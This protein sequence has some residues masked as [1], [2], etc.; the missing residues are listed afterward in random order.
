MRRAPSRPLRLLLLLSWCTAAVACSQ[1]ERPASALL[2]TI[3]TLR[4][5]SVGAYRP[6]DPVPSATPRIDALAQQGVLFEHAAAP[7]PLTRPSHFSI[8][9]SLYPRE[10][11][12]LNNAIALPEAA[13]TLPELLQA[14]GYRTAAF[15][16]VVLLGKSSGAGQGFETLLHPTDP[17]ERPA[18][19]AVDEALAWLANVEKA[20]SFFLWVHVFDPHLPYAPPEAFRPESPTTPGA[21]TSLDWPEFVGI[22][23]ANDGD[24]PAATLER[25]RDLY[26]GE[27]RYADRE[28]GRL[29]D[30][31]TEH[32]RGSDTVVA[33]TAD[34]GEA[35]GHGTY[36]EHADSLFDGAIAIPL[37]V[38]GNA[39]FSGAERVAAQVSSLDIAPTLLRALGLDVPAGLSGSPLQERI[40][41]Q[42]RGE[43]EKRFVLIQHPFYQ[44]RVAQNRPRKRKAIRSVAGEPVD[45]ILLDTEK[46]GIVGTDWKLTRT[47]DAVEL[48]HR[49]S[50]ETENRAAEGGNDLAE[51]SSELDQQLEAHPLELIDT[52]EINDELL[53]ALRALG[54]VH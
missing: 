9:T 29:L 21:P 34:H 2:I 33:L 15:V 51:L 45:E 19:S 40:A 5:D 28:V 36:F 48:Y 47:D 11:G 13:V 7:M 1:P 25:A 54:Y 6:N 12:V 22:A 42:N 31:L 43:V 20:D 10:H 4:A 14:Q 16:S 30:G 23:R 52:A 49:P 38:A 8:L 35:F 17:R 27:V 44:Q 41:A 3:D 53:E 26:R 46:V 18:E 39:T 37:I 32:G 24:I 50:G